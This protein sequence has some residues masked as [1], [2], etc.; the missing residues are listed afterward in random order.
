M[1]ASEASILGTHSKSLF[2]EA[3]G[4]PINFFQE[5]PPGSQERLSPWE[6]LRHLGGH[7]PVFQPALPTLVDAMGSAA[8]N[9]GVS[10]G[11]ATETKAVMALFEHMTDGAVTSYASVAQS[12]AREHV[13]TE[14]IARTIAIYETNRGNNEA[15]AISS[16]LGTVA[17]IPASVP[18]M[19][20]ATMPWMIDALDAS[21]SLR[22]IPDPNLTRK[23]IQDAGS[24][25]EATVNLLAQ[26]DRTADSTEQT[27]ET[28]FK[29]NN[30][31][32]VSSG[33]N[34][35]DVRLM[36]KGRDL[37]KLVIAANQQAAPLAGDDKNAKIDELIEQI[38]VDDRLGIDHGSLRAYIR[39][40]G[41][42]SENRAAWQRL[43]LQRMT[44]EQGISIGSRIEQAATDKG[45]MTMLVEVV[46]NHVWTA[47]QS[48][49]LITEEQVVRLV[50]RTHN[51]SATYPDGVWGE[52]VRLYGS[53]L[54]T[55]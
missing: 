10:A 30:D 52:Y 41:N 28:F 39:D 33:L 45:G 3:M 47:L 5:V 42:W 8:V 14:R 31:L 40:P 18:S 48:D 36:F 29:D 15:R 46:R 23:N 24:R 26:V 27:I 9:A 55:R 37:K 49:P 7:G 22:K 17:G 19:S 51:R 44:D 38:P 32:M 35:Q 11:M 20:Q 13:L 43:S 1:E 54:P 53:Q 34:E 21:P 16:G 4:D 2:K 6:R 25:I 50:A 12:V